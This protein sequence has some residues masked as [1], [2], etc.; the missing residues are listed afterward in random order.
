M[1]RATIRWP[2]AASNVTKARCWPAAVTRCCNTISCACRRSIT[3]TVSNSSPDYDYTYSIGYVS[4]YLPG[5]VSVHYDNYTGTRYPWRSDAN[6][7]F[8]R[9]TINLSWTL[10]F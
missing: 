9:G 4:S 8:R 2:T 6:A 3:P 7:N 5:A 10:P 1:S